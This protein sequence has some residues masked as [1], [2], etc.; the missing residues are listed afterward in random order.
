MFKS[1]R[2]P[3]QA[4]S[5]HSYSFHSVLDLWDFVEFRPVNGL[6]P[7]HAHTLTLPRRPQCL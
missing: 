5:C 2:Y 1:D 3:T 6:H 7:F 4:A